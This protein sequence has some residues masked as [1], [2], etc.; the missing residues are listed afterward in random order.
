[1][2]IKEIRFPTDLA[3][4]SRGGPGYST[5]IS[6]TKSGY[7][8]AI[9]EWSKARHRYSAAYGPRTQAQLEVVRAF[10]HIVRGK[11]YGFR[12]KDWDDYK[13]CSIA[14]TP[15]AT[16]QTLGTGDGVIV[17]FQLYKTYSYGAESYSRAITRPVSGTT[18]VSIQDV[19]DPRWTV[20]TV[21]GIVTF[22]ADITKTI[23]AITQAAQAQ[24]TFTASHGLSVGHTF[25][26]ASV[27]GM[28]QIN[29]Q[30]VTVTAVDSST[31]VTVNVNST[32]YSA[33][34]SGGTIHTIPQTG[35]E[36]KAGYEF[37]VPVRFDTDVMDISIDDWLIGAV[38]VPLVQVRV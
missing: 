4:G 20:S 10:F 12:F 24:I 30:R 17:A 3:Y 2:V 22:S 37:D 21:T 18:L 31:Q 34:T 15:A 7:E 33:Y 25:H 28:T 5:D 32:G 23:N 14:A 6:E 16:D 13:S 35:E 11:G 27:S 26:V 9:L 38:D 36:V 19:T 29:G 8:T 1:M